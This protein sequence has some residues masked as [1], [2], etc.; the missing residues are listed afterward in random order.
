[1]N[2]VNT[3]TIFLYHGVTTCDDDSIRN[4]SNKHMHIREFRRQMQYVKN[5][6]TVLS[7]DDVVEIY[8]SGKE[9]PNKSAAI[10]FDDGFENNYTN[11]A[12]I[13]CD[14]QIPTTFYVCPGMINTNLMFW[15][16]MI[17]DCIIRS[18]QDSVALSL[19][20]KYN[21]KLLSVTDKIHAINTIKGYCKRAPVSEKNRVISEL[22]CASRITPLVSSSEDYKL[23]N[24]Q[25]LKELGS[26]DIFTIGGHT[27]YH[28]I[29]TAMKPEGLSLDI[30]LSIDLLD[31][32]L[33]QKTLH[34]SY[35]EGQSEHYN[36]NIK[37]LLKS[38][39]VVCCPTAIDGLN[40]TQDLFELRRI[41]PGFMG[42]AFPD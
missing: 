9:W 12:D 10:T 37:T 20:Q 14:Y 17:E 42:R 36:E 3:L 26:E 5:N 33:D 28:D 7:M 22:I 32:N 31:Y 18:E 41:M 27:M 13:L 23:M 1:M 4:F 39:G 19:E 25:Q 2:A 6:Y 15:V 38:N 40:N 35:P 11:A 29:M 16:D 24:W 34:F 21:I 8:L 30:S